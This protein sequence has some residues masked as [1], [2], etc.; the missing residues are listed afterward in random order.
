MTKGKGGGKGGNGKRPDAVAPPFS[1]E[2][3]RLGEIA[4][5]MSKSDD[6]HLMHLQDVLWR[7]WPA[8]RARQI[9]L[10]KGSAKEG[11]ETVGFVSWAMM[12]D[13]SL[14]NLR[15]GPHSLRP[16]DWRSG[17]QAVVIDAFG[18]EPRMSLIRMLKKSR[19]AGESLLFWRWAKDGRAETLEVGKGMGAVRGAD[20]E[21]DADDS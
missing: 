17:N 2:L 8:V 20:K 12:D 13:E 16:V 1:K 10:V 15:S 9:M 7:V 14:E 18:S 6:H 4:L 11:G 3:A 19:V 5:M 21:E